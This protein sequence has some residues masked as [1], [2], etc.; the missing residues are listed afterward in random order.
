M[1]RIPRALRSATV[2]GLALFGSQPIL[3]DVPFEN[4][5]FYFVHQYDLS[6]GAW[7]LT[8]GY[9]ASPS[10]WTKPYG[11]LP[12]TSVGV[13]GDAIVAPLG[14]VY[15]VHQNSMEPEIPPD[16]ITPSSPIGASRYGERVSADL[17]RLVVGAPDDGVAGDGAIFLYQRSGSLWVQEKRITGTVTG[18]HFG[19]DVAID[20]NT[21]AAAAG[22]TGSVSVYEI[23]AGGNVVL[24]ASLTG[25]TS[26]FG[27]AIGLSGDAL[28][29]G[30]PNAQN[31]IGEV[32]IY[33]RQGSSWS[34]EATISPQELGPSYFGAS[35]AIDQD[36]IIVGEPNKETSPSIGGA[37]RIYRHSLGS[38]VEE[39]FLV[40]TLPTSLAY[41]AASVDID[42]DRAVVSRPYGGSIEHPDLVAAR[43]VYVYEREGPSWFRT[44]VLGAHDVITGPFADN[45]D[46]N[47][48]RLL[49]GSPGLAGV[50]HYFRHNGT[51][52]SYVLPL[53]SPD[54]ADDFSASVALSG[55]LATIGIPAAESGAVASMPLP[56]LGL[57]TIPSVAQAGGPLSFRVGGGAT[58]TTT[59]L[60]LTGVNAMPVFLPLLPGTLDLDGQFEIA[61]G[62]PPDPNLSGASLRFQAFVA[63]PFGEVVASN[64]R[65]VDFE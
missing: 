32:R 23:Q 4:R 60:A 37:A 64:E 51:K 7:S 13:S 24:R 36:R 18:A 44:Q 33:R 57:M 2:V 38:W 3:A 25:A 29:V 27:R 20:G 17:N 48:E 19:A 28:A 6:G 65:V 14:L 31:S 46:L 39:A 55:G 30:D 43:V 42:G 62:V 61:F 5:L 59:L 40:Q 34:L 45:L 10:A 11:Q 50:A 41:F 52:F 21:V 12:L 26:A 22:G 1:Q 53:G 54:I 35:L 56:S 8:R 9:T 16:T 58:A 63:G 49:V 15:D 47:G